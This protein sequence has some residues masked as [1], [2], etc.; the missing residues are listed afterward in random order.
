MTILQRKLHPDSNPLNM[1]LIRRYVKGIKDSDIYIK[2]KEAKSLD[3]AIK[4]LLL[5]SAK[6][7]CIDLGDLTTGARVFI[8]DD[9]S[10]RPEIEHCNWKHIIDLILKE[11]H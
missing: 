7:S 5:P 4:A 9:E 1:A 11:D 3:E 8:T 6:V 10:I 2:V